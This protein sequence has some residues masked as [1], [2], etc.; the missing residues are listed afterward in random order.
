[1]VRKAGRL[2]SLPQASRRLLRLLDSPGTAPGA[3]SDAILHDPGLTARV[4]A[5][6]N[7]RRERGLG[8]VETVSAALA[9][10]GRDR[11][12]EAAAADGAG[13]LFRGLDANRVDLD[14]FWMN[15]MACAVA[16]R[17]LAL[18]CRLIPPEPLFIAALLHKIG[19]LAMYMASP[20]RYSRVLS[21]EPSDED[22]VNREEFRV[23]GF[24]HAGAGAELLRG[25]GLPDSLYVPVAH[26]LAPGRA[27]RHPRL[28]ALVHVASALAN[29]IE[30]S[31][32]LDEE[33]YRR[34][35]H[36]ERGA[37]MLLELPISSLLSVLDESRD[38]ALAIFEQT[39]AAQPL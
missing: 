24:N 34:G 14:R 28:C 23:F 19:R 37:C 6:A 38:R 1:L 9:V 12:R 15:S 29:E 18:R 25:W 11:L 8:P 13:R 4:L 7:G 17:V 5:L 27:R 22:G 3:I 26:Y 2:W 20:E 39:H 32:G 10:L 36:L 33:C 21:R 31:M 35:I 30:P 16:A